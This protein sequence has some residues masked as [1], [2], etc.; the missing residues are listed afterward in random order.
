MCIRD[1]ICILLLDMQA[2]RRLFD[3]YGASMSSI[4]GAEKVR[5]VVIRVHCS[6]G[7]MCFTHGVLCRLL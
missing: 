1:S 2:K 5:L 4:A 7:Y 6:D 3:G